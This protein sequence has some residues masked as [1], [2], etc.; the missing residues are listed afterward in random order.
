MTALLV[1]KPGLSE[2]QARGLQRL[3]GTV[4]GCLAAGAFATLAASHLWAM[5]A[6]IALTAGLAFALQKASYAVFTTA[7]TATVVLFLSIGRGA[8]IATAEHRLEATLLG[9]AIALA[10]ARIAHRPRPAAPEAEDR[11]GA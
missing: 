2:T 8:A 3:A 1:L 7:V 9:G 11:I 10:V 6:A 5:L 4:G